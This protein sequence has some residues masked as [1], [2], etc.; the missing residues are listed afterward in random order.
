M[1]VYMTV[2]ALDSDKSNAFYDAALAT[3]GWSKHTDFP[4]WRAYSEGGAGLG[5]VLWV[6]KP[7]NGEPATAGNGGMVGFMVKSR[8][9]VDAFYDAAM[10]HGGTDEGAPASRPHYGPT[11]YASYMRD[12]S[13]NKIS[14][15]H[16]D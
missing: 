6:C 16:N 2:G 12:P 3:I 13:G 1:T 7:F 11:W 15:V 10:A 8:G 5:P 9:E 4:G 14:V